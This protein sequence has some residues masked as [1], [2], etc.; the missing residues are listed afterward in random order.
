MILE[1][2][3]L[4]GKIALVTGGTSGIGKAIATGLA[5]AGADVVAP[6]RT[7]EKVQNMVENLKALNS[8][9]LGITTDVTNLEEVEKLKEKII[10]KF[11]KIDILVN[12]AGTTIKGDAEEL[13]MEE[14]RRII[15]LNLNSV[16]STSQIIGRQMIK[17]KHGKIINIASIGSTLALKGSIAYCA[18]K[19]GVLQ[20]TRVLAS[21]WA[22]YG[23]EVNAI[24][25]AYF[26]TPMTSGILD[27]EE[28]MRELRERV[29]M[30][31]LGETEELKGIA[32]FLASPATSYMT[33]ETIFVDGGWTSL[34]I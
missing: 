15:D 34:G 22:E 31:R 8:E 3:D 17:Q 5:E 32:V 20:L 10:E 25:P 14:W 9:T 13:P 23:I 2:F 11:G 33:G 24:A 21:E 19:G 16:F 7:P 12:N 4:S 1:K 18:S 27:S 30:K 28:F 26:K 29:P 6:S